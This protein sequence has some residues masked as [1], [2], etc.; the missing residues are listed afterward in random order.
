MHVK[1]LEKHGL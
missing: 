1:F